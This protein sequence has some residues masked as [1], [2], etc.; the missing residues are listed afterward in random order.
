MTSKLRSDKFLILKQNLIDQQSVSQNG[1]NKVCLVK[2]SF[3][4]A[5]TLTIAGKLITDGEIVKEYTL[6]TVEVILFW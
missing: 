5:R 3:H 6:K 1:H 4:V 2:V